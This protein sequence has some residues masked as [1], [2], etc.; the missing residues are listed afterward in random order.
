MKGEL[1][2]KMQPSTKGE[3]LPQNY[4]DI[5][6]I[7]DLTIAHLQIQQLAPELVSTTYLALNIYQ[8][9]LSAIKNLLN[10]FYSVG[11]FSIDIYVLEARLIIYSQSEMHYLAEMYSQHL[12]NI[13]YVLSTS[14]TS[15]FPYKPVILN[16]LPILSIVFLVMACILLLQKRFCFFF[17]SLQMLV[18]YLSI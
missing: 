16:T 6:I 12:S 10:H 15:C 11:Q 8:Q 3:S 17:L 18:G 7:N 2:W 4:T 14:N 13:Y 9:T 1:F 5:G